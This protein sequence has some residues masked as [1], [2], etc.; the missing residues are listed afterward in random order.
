MGWTPERRADPI[1]LPVY[2]TVR[3]V[4]RRGR[5]Q[6]STFRSPSQRIRPRGDRRE[7]RDRVHHGRHSRARLVGEA[8]ALGSKSRLIG[9]TAGR[10]TR[11]SA[12]SGSA[13]EHLRKGRSG[14]QR[15][16]LT[17]E[18][19]S[20]SMPLG[21]DGGRDRRR[22]ARH[23]F[24]RVRSCPRGTRN[25]VIIMSARSA[26]RPRRMPPSPRRQAAGAEQDTSA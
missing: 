1:G 7:V 26:V 6:R 23:K 19:V 11:A 5:R 10:M 13:G 16:A 4:A 15:R 12:R 17:Y 18:A 2:D 22:S 8:C 24:R 14:G 20:T 3:R 21:N 25:A 9:R